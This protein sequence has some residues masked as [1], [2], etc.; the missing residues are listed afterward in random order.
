MLDKTSVN[1]A[2]FVKRSRA[3]LGLS[4]REFAAKLGLERRTVMRYERGDELPR[5]VRLAMKHLVNL[6]EHKRLRT[7][8]QIKKGESKMAI[9]PGKYD[10]VA[11]DARERT[12]AAGIILMVF[13]GTNGDG[14]SCQ[15]DLET[16]QKL[17]EILEHVAR[18][19]RKD[20]SAL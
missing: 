18:Q 16:T 15:A 7:N 2:N 11:T 13:G 10:Q 1:T 12:K 19:I 5:L 4:Q 14:F 3:K 9:G 8:G 17:P 6:H 20:A